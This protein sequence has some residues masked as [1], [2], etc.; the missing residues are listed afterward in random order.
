[1]RPSSLA[2]A[3]VITN[4]AQIRLFRD[5][6]ENTPDLLILAMS[7]WHSYKTLKMCSKKNLKCQEK[8]VAKLIFNYFDFINRKPKNKI[9]DGNILMKKFN[10]KPGKIIGELLK[11]INNAYEENRIK[12]EKSA[13]NFVKPQLTQLKEKYKIK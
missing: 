7:D 4:K 12:N 3:E 8:F 2:K 5:I 9:I 13:L 11:I 1:M 6:K 10:L